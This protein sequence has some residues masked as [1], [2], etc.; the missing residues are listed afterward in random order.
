MFYKDDKLALF[1]DLP[2]TL[3][4]AS[5][6]GFS[7]DFRLLKNEFMRRG[8][9]N[10]I[11]VYSTTVERDEHDNLKPMLDWMQF[12]GFHTKIKEV[13]EKNRHTQSRDIEIAVDALIAAD[14]IDHIVI[15]SGSGDLENVV[16]EIQR[17]C[18]RVSIVSTNKDE[19]KMVSKNLRGVADNFIELDDLRDTI[20]RPS[21]NNA[22]EYIGVR[23]TK[24]IGSKELVDH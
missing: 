10:R 4:A 15:F 11:R 20:G 24:E 5:S 6:L 8:K 22:H 12:H 3:H 13:K 17:K 9:L 2:N 21:D 16:R 19:L 1:I 23:Q 18:V 14:N 7:I